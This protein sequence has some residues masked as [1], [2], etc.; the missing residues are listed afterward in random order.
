MTALRM[1]LILWK[2]N[3]NLASN[4]VITAAVQYVPHAVH[5]VRIEYK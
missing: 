2:G 3:C 1:E 5:F 4:H